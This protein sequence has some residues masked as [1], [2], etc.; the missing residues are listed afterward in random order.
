[1]SLARAVASDPSV[2][3]YAATSPYEWGGRDGRA[4]YTGSRSGGS[5][6]RHYFLRSL[7]CIELGL[8]QP[9]LPPRPALV[10]IEPWR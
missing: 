3:D 10:T 2:G 6:C 7:N 8:P 5:L 9:L 1:M 4:Q